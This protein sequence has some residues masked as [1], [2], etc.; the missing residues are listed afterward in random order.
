MIEYVSSLEGIREHNLQGFFVGWP[1]PPDEST[2]LKILENSDEIV[3]AVETSDE[4]VVGFITAITDKTLM[5]FIPLLEVLP[6]YQGRGIGGELVERMLRRLSGFYAID[7]MCDRALQNFYKRFGMQPASG[8][9]V[10]RNYQNQ[11][12]NI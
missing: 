2:F 11:S 8:G 10:L 12:G 4:Q 6:S 9:M 7:L 3:L 5:A 1:N